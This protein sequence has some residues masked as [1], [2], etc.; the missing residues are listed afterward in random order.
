MQSFLEYKHSGAKCT[1]FLLI[2][3]GFEMIYKVGRELEVV[4]DD[5]AFG[6]NGV[7]RL[8]GL[9]CFIPFSIPGERLKIRITS[10][11]KRFIEAEIVE[12]LEASPNRVEPK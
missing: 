8:D 6:G 3:V 5:V 2:T 10:V 9:V 1:E 4:V 11:K 12:I 7:T